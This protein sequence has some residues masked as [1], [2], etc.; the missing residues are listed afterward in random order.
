MSSI[1]TNVLSNEELQYLNNRPEV[2][3]AKA[4]MDS[5]QSGMVYFSVPITSSIRDTL[6]SRFG[7]Q[8]PA[9]SQI[10][11]RWI[12]GDTAPHIDVGSSN[13][14]TTYLLYL[15]DSP[16]ELIVD[17]QAYPIQCNTGFVFNEG[18]VHE[19]KYT[20]NV[21][22][23]LLGPMNEFVEPVGGAPTGIYYFST[24]ADALANRYPNIGYSG[25]Q[26][27]T[28]G[29]NEIIPNLIPPYTSWRIASNSVGLSSQ[30]VV[31]RNG[32]VLNPLDSNGY[33]AYYY[34]YPSTP[35]FLEGTT[36][37]CKIDEIETYIPI[38]L[39]KTGTL[40][41]TSLDGYKPVLLIGKGK[42][43]NPGDNE[44]TENRLY[45]CSTSKY[46]QLKDDLY[47]TG[48]HSIL[49][50]SITEKQKEKIIQHLGK[51]FITDKKYRVM[52][53][54]D[55]RSEPWNSKGEYTIWHFAIDSNDERINYGVYVNGG[56]IV[57]TCSISFLKNK[58]NMD[59][60]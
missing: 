52:A 56:L 57:E 30:S 50:S 37:L 39:I 22:R 19:S 17:S 18:I 25:Y 2:F 48:C 28:V 60:I 27:Y 11:M 32:D 16:G 10:P 58:S 23:L 8:M 42:I 4:D 51:V 13:F 5:K 46:P 38:E 41:K 20:E 43:Q 49:E 29:Q 12:K 44:R 21:P 33:S 45:K 14:Q 31:Y 15:N 9:Y 36:V 34:L 3:A 54:I 1:Y 24:E 35:C 59:V 7:L 55:E 53:Y 26:E 40:V 47:I 6:Q